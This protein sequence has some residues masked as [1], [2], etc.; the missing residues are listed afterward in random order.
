L[1]DNQ[2]AGALA[3]QAGHVAIRSSTTAGGQALGGFVHNQELRVGEQ[4][5][6]NGQ[7]LLLTARQLLRLST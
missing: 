6:R 1:L 2:Q 3:G 7:H 5:S 4:R